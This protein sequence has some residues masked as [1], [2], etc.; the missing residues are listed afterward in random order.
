[1]RSV[2]QLRVPAALALIAV[3]LRMH[4]GGGN[5]N[6]AFDLLVRPAHPSAT[7]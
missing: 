6:Y 2:A 5:H 4:V 7:L 1:M 3:L